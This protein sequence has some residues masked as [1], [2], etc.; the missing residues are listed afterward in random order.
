ME[1]SAH[2][3]MGPYDDE[4]KITLRFSGYVPG[5]SD[6]QYKSLILKPERMTVVTSR[7]PSVTKTT[8]T[9][10]HIKIELPGNPRAAGLA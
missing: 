7:Y 3:V 10:E 6:S 4:R 2:Y 1:L 8:L 5:I 9:K